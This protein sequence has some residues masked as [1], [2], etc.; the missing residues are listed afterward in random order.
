MKDHEYLTRRISYLCWVLILSL[1][2]FSTGFGQIS[3][4]TLKIL[5][6][7]DTHLCNLDNYQAKFINARNHYGDGVKPLET[8]FNTIP[9][10]QK[11]DALIM[12]GDII[13]FYEAKTPG[14]EFLA[15]QIEQF[16]PLFNLSLLKNL[17]L[18]LLLSR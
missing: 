18:R 9:K 11:A 17:L 15:T 3:S 7:S 1:L 12:T 2:C 6:I 10:S 16:Y 4:D 5:H 8:F 13:D 14:G